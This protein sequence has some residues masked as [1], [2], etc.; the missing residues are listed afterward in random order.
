MLS[1][2]WRASSGERIGVLPRFTTCLGPRTTEAGGVGAGAPVG[3][4]VERRGQIYSAA[5]D[6]QQAS[7]VFNEILA[8]LER[9]PS[10]MSGLHVQRWQK[11]I[12]DT[13]SGTVY[14]A[15]S[16]N[17]RK[18]HGL[19]PSVVIADELAQ[20]R[21]REL[22]DNLVIG[23]G[24]RSE[25]LMVVISTRSPDPNHLMTKDLS[26]LVL[27]LPGGCRRGPGVVLATSGP[28][29]RAPGDRPGAL[30]GLAR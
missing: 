21:S 16:S 20:W 5:T 14:G 27:Y 15:L 19:N 29:R 23:M 17:A 6:R 11:S 4:E 7:I 22:Y 13:V 8:M 1:T 3:P 18:A 26:A 9:R 10:L 12:T 24:A 28:A 30:P 25:P 2:S